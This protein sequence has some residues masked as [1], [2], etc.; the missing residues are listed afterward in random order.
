MDD[1]IQITQIL[2]ARRRQQPGR[3]P[4]CRRQV[5]GLRRLMRLR[6]LRPNWVDC[7]VEEKG[8]SV[9][10]SFWRLGFVVLVIYYFCVDAVGGMLSCCFVCYLYVFLSLLVR[11]CCCCVCWMLCWMMIVIGLQR[12]RWKK[13]WM[14]GYCGAPSVL[15]C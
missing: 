3:S 9:F 2:I 5:A 6:L 1:R 4:L 10:V 11:G 14:M 7:S 12:K 13:S 8:D 15:I